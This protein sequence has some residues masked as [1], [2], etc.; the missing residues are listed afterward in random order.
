MRVLDER[1]KMT[2]I[3]RSNGVGNV[4][5]GASVEFQGK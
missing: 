3:W 5:G 2:G 1:S 4:W